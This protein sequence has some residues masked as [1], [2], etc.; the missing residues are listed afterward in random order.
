MRKYKVLRNTKLVTTYNLGHFMLKFK[1][2][3][4]TW[5]VLDFSLDFRSM[6]GWMLWVMT[7]LSFG[8][9]IVNMGFN[10]MFLVQWLQNL[11][12]SHERNI[13][14]CLLGRYLGRKDRYLNETMPGFTKEKF[15]LNPWIMLVISNSDQSAIEILP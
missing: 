14:S 9:D 3:V 8:P 13:A 2:W 11:K 10:N 12:W 5:T 7:W 1:L 6:L 15:H 4:W